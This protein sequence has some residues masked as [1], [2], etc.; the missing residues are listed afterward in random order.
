MGDVGSRV[1][2]MKVEMDRNDSKKEEE[3]QTNPRAQSSSFHNQKKNPQSQ[4]WEE[5]KDQSLG[6]RKGEIKM[7]E[8]EANR[9]GSEYRE[10]WKVEGLISLCLGR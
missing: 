10:K 5:Q 2:G 7:A 8:I 4:P 1:F 9:V 3:D 6:R